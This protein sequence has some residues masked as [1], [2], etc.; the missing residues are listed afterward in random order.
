MNAAWPCPVFSG[1][2][3]SFEKFSKLGTVK[4][5]SVAIPVSDRGSAGLPVNGRALGETFP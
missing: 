2:L 5:F 3:N 4:L 1:P